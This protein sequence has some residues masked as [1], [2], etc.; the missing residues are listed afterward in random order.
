VSTYSNFGYNHM[1]ITG[2]LHEKLMRFYSLKRLSG[3]SLTCLGESLA[4][5]D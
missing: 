5:L 4:Y 1:T 2:G 3:G